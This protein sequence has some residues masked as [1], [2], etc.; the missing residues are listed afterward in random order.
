MIITLLV[1]GIFDTLKTINQKQET[2]ILLVEQNARIALDFSKYGY[3][4]ENGKIVLD[5]PSEAVKENED[6]KE[7]YL[8]MTDEDTKKSY[9][10]VKHYKRRK[11]WLS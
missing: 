6:V 11:R 2:G 7:F 1:K 9:A 5:G 4:M 3:I 10:D 8:G